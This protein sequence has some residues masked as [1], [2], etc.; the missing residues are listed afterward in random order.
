MAD[1]ALDYNDFRD[2]T[3]LIRGLT[4]LAAVG[5]FTCGSISIPLDNRF[6]G[7]YGQSL[8]TLASRTGFEPV[9]PT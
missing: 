7:S 4:A 9:L 5:R 6:A 2:L 8:I 3:F 1:A